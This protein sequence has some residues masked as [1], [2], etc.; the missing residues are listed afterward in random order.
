MRIL[1]SLEIIRVSGKTLNEIRTIPKMVSDIP[2]FDF[3]Y[4]GKGK[5]SITKLIIGFY[6]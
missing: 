3:V 4:H 5:C 1:R 6:P 2:S